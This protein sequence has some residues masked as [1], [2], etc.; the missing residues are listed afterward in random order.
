MMSTMIAVLMIS[1]ALVGFV[2]QLRKHAEFEER[3]EEIKVE[4]AEQE[5]LLQDYR[6]RKERFRNDPN[7]VRK[8]AHEFG[9]V[10]PHEVIFRFYDDSRSAS[11]R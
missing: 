8:V 11:R 9:M 4:N 5:R 2:P 6:V 3:L 1:A 7:Y 10:E